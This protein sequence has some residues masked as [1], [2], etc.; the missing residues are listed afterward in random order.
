MW[1]NTLW[2]NYQ[3]SAKIW[4]PYI[5]ESTQDS[6]NMEIIIS[7]N[8]IFKE[9]QKKID[10]FLNKKFKNNIEFT[11]KDFEYLIDII[12]RNNASISR[13]Q[14]LKKFKN[15]NFEYILNKLIKDLEK[16]FDTI[17]ANMLEKGETTNLFLA[18]D[19]LEKW[20]WYKKQNFVK[21][22]FLLENIVNSPI[23]DKIIE[24]EKKLK[25]LQNVYE[26]EKILEN[27]TQIDFFWNDYELLNYTDKKILSIFINLIK[28]KLK[29]LYLN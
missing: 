3:E 26:K 25:N 17:F 18:I 13:L 7:L 9:K 29:Q 24:I 2:N 19:Y 4:K 23:K 12:Y 10:Q 8:K 11:T 22:Y 14:K 21:T 1:L 15:S 20:Y 27:L 28:T 6:I 16:N 5:L